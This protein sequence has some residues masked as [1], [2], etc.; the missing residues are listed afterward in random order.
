MEEG[1]QSIVFVQIADDPPRY[2]RRLVSTSRRD[3][4]RV[5][6]RSASALEMKIDCRPLKAG[7]KVVCS[8]AVQLLATLVNLQSA[9]PVN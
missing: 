8:G 1:S 3:G 9:S 4:D 7:E 6:I 2:E 5:Y